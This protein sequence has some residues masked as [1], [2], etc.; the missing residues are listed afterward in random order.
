MIIVTY[1]NKRSPG[2]FD[3]EVY[4]SRILDQDA[5]AFVLRNRRKIR[6]IVLYDF[7]IPLKQY[8]RYGKPSVRDFIKEYKGL[9]E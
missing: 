1:D 6:D 2:G 7:E 8:L 3:Y 9:C 5:Y 4:V